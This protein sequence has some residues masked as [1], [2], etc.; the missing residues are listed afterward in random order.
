MS[1][2]LLSSFHFL[3]VF[4]LVAI[5]AAQST[6]IGPGMTT[7]GMRLAAS[8][9]RAYGVSAVLLLGVGFSRVW[10]GAKGSAFYL[11]NPLF[12][13]KIGLF[14]TVA[15]LSIPPTLQLIRWTKQA[16]L[17]ADFLPPMEQ[18]QRIQCVATCRRSGACFHPV[19]CSGYGPWNR[20]LVIS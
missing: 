7:D 1:D 17:Q 8:L 5:L 2:L 16:E 15:V 12:W 19:P 10:W 14:A 3:L 13:A 4:L 9:D 18:V 20:N 6:L 11:S